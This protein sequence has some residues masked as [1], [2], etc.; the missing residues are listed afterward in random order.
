[1]LRNIFLS[2]CLGTAC[3]WH[4][5]KRQISKYTLEILGYGSS[6]KQAGMNKYT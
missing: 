4:Q 2:N 3:I 6:Q 1:M 5:K